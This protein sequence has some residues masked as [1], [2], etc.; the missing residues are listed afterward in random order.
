MIFPPSYAASNRSTSR[1][2]GL[3]SHSHFLTCQLRPLQRTARLMSCKYT[4]KSLEVRSR[5]KSSSSLLTLRIGWLSGDQDSTI[6][7]IEYTTANTVIHNVQLQSPQKYVEINQQAQDGQ[8]YFAMTS[9][10]RILQPLRDPSLIRRPPLETW[11]HL[12]D[13]ARHCMSRSVP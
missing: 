5:R 13:R 10:S 2:T 1:Q 7:W 3:Y 12:A 4:R 8:A 6:Q 11:P 9:V